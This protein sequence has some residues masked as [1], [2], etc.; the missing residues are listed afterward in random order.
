MFYTKLDRYESLS[1]EAMRDF[2]AVLP[3][4]RSA[5][6]EFIAGIAADSAGLSAGWPSGWVASF[7][8]SA[9]ATK[10]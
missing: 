8:C 2:A 1:L 9:L 6:A 5:H 4:D 3:V 10:N 7:S